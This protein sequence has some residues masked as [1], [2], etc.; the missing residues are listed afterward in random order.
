MTN[1][2]TNGELLK[3]TLLWGWS[4]GEPM[5]RILAC[6]WLPKL[7]DGWHWQGRKAVGPGGAWCEPGSTTQTVLASMARVPLAIIRAVVAVGNN[8]PIDWTLSGP[9]EGW[10]W[11][12]LAGNV[13]G[14]RNIRGTQQIIIARDEDP[15]T[16]DQASR[17]ALA[18]VQ[19]RELNDPY[20]Y[21][22]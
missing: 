22:V 4:P 20:S 16:W 3:P 19:L 15:G 7:L 6:Y 18:M 5:V 8:K 17:E 14:I 2:K 9:L 11:T 10:V 1:L 21:D 12:A 13:W